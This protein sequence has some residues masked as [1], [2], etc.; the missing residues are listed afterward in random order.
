M[1][2]KRHSAGRPH[3]IWHVVA[4]FLLSFLHSISYSIAQADPFLA[5]I[6]LLFPR[7]GQETLIRDPGS[8]LQVRLQGG[9]KKGRRQWGGL[10]AIHTFLGYFERTEKPKIWPIRLWGAEVNYNP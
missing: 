10:P 6:T 9:D 5:K 2:G 8:E 1:P 7:Y 4:H 3:F